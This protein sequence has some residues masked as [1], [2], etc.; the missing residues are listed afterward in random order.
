MAII[1]T[2]MPFSDNGELIQVDMQ[3]ALSCLMFFNTLGIYNDATYYGIKLWMDAYMTIGNAPMPSGVLF[4]SPLGGYVGFTQLMAE[5]EQ[6]W[7]A[8]E[9]FHLTI[10]EEEVDDDESTVTGP[11]TQPEYEPYAL[12]DDDSIDAMLNIPVNIDFNLGFFD[13]MDEE[14]V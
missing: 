3:K 7:A 5:L 14:D 12:D 2:H 11:V 4:K 13:E 8:R 9:A 6:E 10:D 1:N